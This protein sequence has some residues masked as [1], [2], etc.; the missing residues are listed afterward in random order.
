MLAD[1]FVGGNLLDVFPDDH[2][3]GMA[4][5][6]NC[7]VWSPRKIFICITINDT[8]TCSTPKGRPTE[9]L[10]IH[11]FEYTAVSDFASVYTPVRTL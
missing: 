3:A 1:R 7:A 6:L 4:S 10:E 11:E 8:E 2:F 5:D 9:E